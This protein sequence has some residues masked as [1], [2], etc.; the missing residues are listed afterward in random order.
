MN[1]QE[2]SYGSIKIDGITFE[3]DVII[4]CGEVSKRRKKPS[5][6]YRDGFGHTPVSL[7]EILP[8]NCKRL[9]IG[10]GMNGALPVMGEVKQEA[11][12]RKVE[13]MIIPTA[14]AIKKLNV[15]MDDT[16]AVLHLTC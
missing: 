7:E 16:N 12:S 6:K 5:K 9:V 2:Y 4:D 13:L 15:G 3:Q 10:T 8:W 1:F 11:E 14:E